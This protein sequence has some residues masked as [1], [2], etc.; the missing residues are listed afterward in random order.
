M[1]QD[2]IMVRTFSR[3]YSMDYASSFFH[4]LEHMKGTLLI[5]LV[6]VSLLSV[7]SGGT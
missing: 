4:S 2:V 1:L 3:I 6:G 5:V 7:A